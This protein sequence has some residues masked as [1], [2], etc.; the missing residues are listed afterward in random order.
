M[1]AENAAYE[2]GRVTR[3]NLNR[4]RQAVALWDKYRSRF[5]SGLLRKEA[6]LSILDTLSSLGDTRAALA[7]ADAFLARHPGSERRFEVQKLAERLR[8][9]DAAGAR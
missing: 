5:P 4:P 6:D 1:A 9:A 7:E 8:A 3:Y 2:L